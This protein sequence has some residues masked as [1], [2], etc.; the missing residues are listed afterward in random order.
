MENKKQPESSREEYISDKQ[1]DKAIENYQKA[2]E[3]GTLDEKYPVLGS[4]KKQ[5]ESSWEEELDK[6]HKSL[7]QAKKLLSLVENGQNQYEEGGKLW[8]EYQRDI[9]I[10]K[11]E[12]KKEEVG[13]KSFIS[14]VVSEAEKRAYN[15]ALE[16][17]ERKVE[18]LKKEHCGRKDCEQGVCA[19]R[20]A[21]NTYYG[22]IIEALK[23]LKK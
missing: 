19:T 4:R 16:E 15:L 1:M 22:D 13:F 8:L 12:L 5:P 7:N 20:H 2:K 14:K 21:R 18:K 10:A 9:D 6:K 11:E 17:V 23:A 3:D